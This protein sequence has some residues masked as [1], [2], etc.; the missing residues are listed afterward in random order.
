MRRSRRSQTAAAHHPSYSVPD[1]L[2]IAVG[3]GQHRHEWVVFSTALREGWLMLQCVECGEMGVVKD[4]S[5]AEWSEAFRAPSRPYRWK[6]GPRVVEQGRAFARVIRAIDGPAC[7]CPSQR[8]LPEPRGYE[9]V[10]GGI[11]EHSDALSPEDRKELTDL[12]DFV[13]QT[14]LCSFLFPLFIRSCE[15]DTQLRHCGAVHTIIGRIGAWDEAGIHCSPSVVARII[16]EYA[17]WEAVGAATG[18]V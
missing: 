9:R 10:P 12:A 1:V 18:G 3:G 11:W 16:R 5:S 13:G 15:A 8:S 4:P 14:D 2:P 7:P 17:A 6:D